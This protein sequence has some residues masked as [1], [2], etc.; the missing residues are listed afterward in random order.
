MGQCFGPEQGQLD[1]VTSVLD[2]DLRCSTCFCFYLFYTVKSFDPEPGFFPGPVDV[3]RNQYVNLNRTGVVFVTNVG[4][5][6]EQNSWGSGPEPGCLFGRVPAGRVRTEEL[7]LHGRAR[8][9]EPG[10]D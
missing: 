2:S 4:P 6:D 9:V 1:Q 5:A 8:F 10:L 7:D 3:M